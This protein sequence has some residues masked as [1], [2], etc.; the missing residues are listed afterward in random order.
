[1]SEEM[2]EK[3]TEALARFQPLSEEEARDRHQRIEREFNQNL[4]EYELLGNA[5]KQVFFIFHILSYC[6]QSS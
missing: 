5:I 1:M 2:K 6:S 4:R 3:I